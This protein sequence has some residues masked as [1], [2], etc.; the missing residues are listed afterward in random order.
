MKYKNTN[1]QALKQHN[2]Y[3]YQYA[4]FEEQKTVVQLVQAVLNEK[5][6]MQEVIQS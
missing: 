1:A 4:L 5:V 3:I 6:T 2:M